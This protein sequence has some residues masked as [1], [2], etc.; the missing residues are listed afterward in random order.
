MKLLFIGT[1]VFYNITIKTYESNYN[2]F[3]TIKKDI[4]LN[5]VLNCFVFYLKNADKNGKK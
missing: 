5:L 3:I 2:R 4:N 1:S